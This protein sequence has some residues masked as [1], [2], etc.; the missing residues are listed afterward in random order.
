MVTFVTPIYPLGPLEPIRLIA[1]RKNCLPTQLIHR[2]ASKQTQCNV[3]DVLHGTVLIE[4]Q[5]E[6]LVINTCMKWCAHPWVITIDSIWCKRE[7]SGQRDVHVATGW[8]IFKVPL[9][10][11]SS[12][13]FVNYVTP[14][15]WPLIRYAPRRCLNFTYFVYLL[16]SEPS[17]VSVD[18][19]VSITN[20]EDAIVQYG[21]R[22]C[23]ARGESVLTLWGQ[24]ARIWLQFWVNVF[25]RKL[26]LTSV[27]KQCSCIWNGWLRENVPITQKEAFSEH[28]M[29]SFYLNFRVITE[30]SVVFHETIHIGQIRNRQLIIAMSIHWGWMFF[31]SEWG[32]S[33]SE[34]PLVTLEFRLA[35]GI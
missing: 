35:L 31:C 6:C 5:F 21:S 10:P 1:I 29:V 22:R 4:F 13:C 2:Y 18:A 14:V 33:Q 12:S 28:W 32:R 27:N 26:G 3:L 19:F 7:Q 34:I 24:I 17:L 8:V 25:S 23:A 30:Q 11:Q 16:C 20:Q 15:L 9:P